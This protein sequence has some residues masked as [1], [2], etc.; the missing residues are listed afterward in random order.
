MC[1]YALGTNDTILRGVS[2][3]PTGW[4][5]VNPDY[6]AETRI[7]YTAASGLPDWEGTITGSLGYYN[8]I[9]NYAYAEEIDVG[10]GV[11]TLGAYSIYNIGNL[12]SLTLPG[13]L[14]TIGNNACS[15]NYLLENVTLNEGIT[16]IDSRMFSDCTSLTHLTIPR[17]V[18]SIDSGAFGNSTSNSSSVTPRAAEPVNYPSALTDVTMI[19]K[20]TSAVQ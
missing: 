7:K 20:T 19:G 13:S 6:H 14:T 18:S 4:T 10:Y 5:V 8:N 17:T 1:P 16:R 2:N 9:P 3:C 12:K 15:N 11:T